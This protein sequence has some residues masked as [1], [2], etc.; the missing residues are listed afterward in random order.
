MERDGYIVHL[1]ELN[2]KIYGN[3][4]LVCVIIQIEPDLNNT[5]YQEKMEKRKGGF[6]F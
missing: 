6:K 5:I 1:E 2:Y 4:D 3:K